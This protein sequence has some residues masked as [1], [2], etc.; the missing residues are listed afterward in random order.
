[1]TSQDSGR[2][3]LPLNDQARKLIDDLPQA[4]QAKLDDLIATAADKQ[5]NA[6]EAAVDGAMALV[7]RPLRKQIRKLLLR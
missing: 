7:P 2:N 6:L 3:S 5:Q 4:E 1:M